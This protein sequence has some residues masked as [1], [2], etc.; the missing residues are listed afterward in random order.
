M[1]NS[2]KPRKKYRPKP[3]LA[4]PMAWLLEGF[5]PL[6]QQS[7]YM[8][9]LRLQNANAMDMMTRGIAKSAH[10]NT[11]LAA[12]NVTQALI[13]M[14]LGAEYEA[15]A[16]NGYTALKSLGERGEQ[17]GRFVCRGPEIGHVKGLMEL[18]DA[19]LAV[20]TLERL[21]RAIEICKAKKLP[22]LFHFS[23]QER[24]SELL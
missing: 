20:T 18:H 6:E 19:Q 15:V 2:T 10:M 23:I 8:L 4:N 9:N 12:S 21:E 14:G 17:M 7:E 1:P 13:S 3:R 5:S 11:L 24:T 22:R 16:E